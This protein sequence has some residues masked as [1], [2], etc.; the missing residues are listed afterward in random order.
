MKTYRLE[1][2]TRG[3]FVGDFNPSV[4]RSTQA[5]VGVKRYHQGDTEERH[6]HKVASEVTLI[7]DGQVRMNDRIFSSG[8]IVLLEPGVDT[9]FEAL[10]NVTT[11]VVKLP[12]VMGDKYLC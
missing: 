10:T 2:M 8:D 1:D 3:W 6:V 11:V 9:D 5:E 4:I 12:S 7:L